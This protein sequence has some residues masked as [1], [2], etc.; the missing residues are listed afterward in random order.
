MAFKRGG[1]GAPLKPIPLLY[2]ELIAKMEDT[3]LEV[4]FV[5]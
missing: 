5:I 3:V 4:S 1:G 2:M